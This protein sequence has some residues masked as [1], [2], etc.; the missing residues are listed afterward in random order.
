MYF[1]QSSLNP[2]RLACLPSEDPQTH[3]FKVGYFPSLP[4]FLRVRHR[5]G[6][7]IQ[8]GLIVF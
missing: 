7:L 6:D 3:L 1:R 2:I 8:T 5:W 4:P